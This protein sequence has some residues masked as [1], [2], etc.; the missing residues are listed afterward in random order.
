MMNLDCGKQY[1]RTLEDSGFTV[2]VASNAKAGWELLATACSPDL[3]I[4]DHH[5]ARGRRL[6]I[7]T[8]T[9]RGMPDL[10]A[11]FP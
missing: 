10:I 1:R 4:S 3:I 7:F 6:P 5:D 11:I 9:A 2:D 8:A